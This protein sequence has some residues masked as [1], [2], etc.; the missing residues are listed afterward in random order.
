MSLTNQSDLEELLQR[1][2]VQSAEALDR[3]TGVLATEQASAIRYLKARGIWGSTIGC[4]H[5]ADLVT[6]HLRSL[7]LDLVA[8]RKASIKVQPCL[9]SS[10]ELRRL[11]ERINSR[12]DREVQRI[13]AGLPGTANIVGRLDT[14]LLGDRLSS[15]LT[16][17][18]RQLEKVCSETDGK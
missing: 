8:L 4:S 3:M 7:A 16:E 5:L 1:E 9:A 15:I 14:E 13:V 12:L 11:E 17:V 6:K 10:D 2:E 18:Q